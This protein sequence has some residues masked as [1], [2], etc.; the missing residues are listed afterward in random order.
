MRAAV[1]QRNS[2]AREISSITTGLVPVITRTNAIRLGFVALLAYGLIAPH[3]SLSRFIDARIL[4]VQFRWLH[5]NAPK[6]VA[7]DVVIVG[8]DENSTRAL[9]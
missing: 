2:R 6:P 5:A 4:D 9:F 3:T 1:V 8:I 7:N